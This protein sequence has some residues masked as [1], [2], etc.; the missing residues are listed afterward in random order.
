MLRPDVLVIDDFDRI[1]YLSGFLGSIDRI[2]ERV[3]L[4]LVTMN[5]KEKLDPAVVRAG[6]FTDQFKVQRVRSVH[7]IIP[8]A[9]G[10]LHEELQDWPIA[11]LDELRIRIDV[12]GWE[13]ATSES[14]MAI[15][16]QRVEDN[17]NEENKLTTEASQPPHVETKSEVRW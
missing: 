14:R 12:L 6:R 10:K 15:M 2:R 4:F 8:E 1:P 5:N 16:R 11:F 17:E 9:E 7:D 13:E 3:K